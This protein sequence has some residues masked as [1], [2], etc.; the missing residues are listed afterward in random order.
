MKKKL[1]V[2]K[3]ISSQNKNQTPKEEIN[4]TLVKLGDD[5]KKSSIGCSVAE[6][7]PS[8]YGERMAM[9]I[10]DK[11]HFTEQNEVLLVITEYVRGS[12]RNQINKIEEEIVTLS[13]GRQRL[14]SSLEIFN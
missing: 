10:I 6:K 2:G 11:F 5:C 3:V 9:E 7:S 14:I 1:V 4:P 13:D 8:D 12:R